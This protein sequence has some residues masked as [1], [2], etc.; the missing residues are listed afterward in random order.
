MYC[1]QC[2]AP[3]P[4][5]EKISV[6]CSRCGCTMYRNPRPCVSVLVVSHG[7]VLLGR[8][9]DTASIMPGKWCLPCGHVEGDESFLD[10]AKREVREE[11]GVEITPISIVNVVTNHFSKAYESLVVVLTAKAETEEIIAG[12]DLV[13][14]EWYPL[15]SPLPDMAF[16][17]DLHIIRHYCR[18]GD[19]LGIP[20][21]L[22]ACEFFETDG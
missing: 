15:E 18:W 10:A 1:I 3:L 13:Q 5:S 11:T 7:N 8:R 12:D 4:R 14:A 9:A 2:G 22:T 19:A 20:L 17:A 16:Q 6:R 21:S